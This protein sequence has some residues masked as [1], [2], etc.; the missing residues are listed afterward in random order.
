MPELP[1]VETIKRQLN[2]NIRGKKIK[3]VEVRLPKIINCPA[4]VFEK[5]IAGKSI[6]SIERKAKLLLINFSGNYTLV[7][8]LKLTGQLILT[9]KT[10]EPNKYTHVIFYLD[11]Q[12]I[13]FNDLRQFG[14]IKLV[15]TDEVDNLIFKEKI[16]PEPLEKDFTLKTFKNLLKKKKK[17]KIKPLLMD[18]SFIAGI[19]NV[20][21][22]EILFL[23]GVH[24]ERKAGSLTKED[25]KKIYGNIK[26]VLLEAIK[27]KGTS[28][29]TYLD[30]YGKKG[31]YTLKLKVYNKAGKLCVKCGTKIRVIKQGGR[32]AYFCPKCQK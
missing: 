10:A 6:K 29:D 4:S 12:K 30:A 8:H 2:Q 22:A 1:E 15:K 14:Y 9:S 32:S 26:K 13:F 16:G 19:G 21:S 25:I 18:Q 24:P 23:S 28:V 27:H 11:S 3:K 31:K 20:Y 7:I 17:S 5:N